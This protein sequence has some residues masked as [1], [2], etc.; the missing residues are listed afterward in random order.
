MNMTL[1][2]DTPMLSLGEFSRRTGISIEAVRR[3]CESGQLPFIQHGTGGTRYIN[4]LQL[5]QHCAEANAD[6]PHNKCSFS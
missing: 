2:L 5:T 6:K 1:S 4:M 3:Q